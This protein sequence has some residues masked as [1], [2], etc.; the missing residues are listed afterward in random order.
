MQDR[1]V[2]PLFHASGVSV[3]VCVCVCWTDVVFMIHENLM[4]FE[5]DKGS[6]C[7]LR[8]DKISFIIIHDRYIILYSMIILL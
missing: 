3:C 4:N 7:S 2:R 1:R 6:F 5:R 8:I